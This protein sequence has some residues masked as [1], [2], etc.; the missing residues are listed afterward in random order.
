MKKRL[1][2]AIALGLFVLAMP[3][4]ALADAAIVQL[5]CHAPDE[6]PNVVEVHFSVI[7]FSLPQDVCSISLRSEPFP[8]WPGCVPL[9]VQPTPGW[10]GALNNLGGADW[11]VNGASCIGQQQMAGE[12]VVALP[13]PDSNFC[14]Y[15]AQYI[16]AAGEVMLE[17]EECFYCAVVPTESVDWGTL[18][19][20]YR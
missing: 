7:N 16:N 5:W 4:A 11:S 18:K 13:D 6:H 8:P 12:F 9:W 3:V 20:L 17:Q 19:S 2:P 1:L 15:I 10:D 14:C